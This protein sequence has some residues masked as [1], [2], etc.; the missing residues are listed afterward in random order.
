MSYELW[1][2]SKVNTIDLDI[3]MLEE[4]GNCKNNK[5]TKLVL[6]TYFNKPLPRLPE[7]IKQVDFGG[8][9]AQDISNIGDH[10]ETLKFNSNKFIHNIGTFSKKLKNLYIHADNIESNIDMKD[11]PNELG[12]LEII[13]TS[14]NNS[15]QIN[16]TKL[17]SLKIIS[18]TYNHEISCLPI[19]T[20]VLHIHS[21]KFNQPLDNLPHNLKRLYIHS[22]AFNQPLDNLPPALEELTLENM[23]SFNKILS[24]LPCGIKY[25]SLNFRP[26]NNEY[27]HD[28]TGLI[29]CKTL[30][31]AN[32][33]GNLN[34]LNN[35]IE[36]LNIWCT[37]NVIYEF[38]EY[39]KHWN[40]FP[41]NLKILNI[42]RE[43]V[44]LNAIHDMT[45]IIKANIPCSN[46]CINGILY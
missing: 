38:R 8:N 7:Y 24:N 3:N 4:L 29:N 34:V 41:S 40:K 25:F 17:A 13:C 15:I 26:F 43:L 39:L 6:D 28:I 46:I 37:P 14:F 10:I 1:F 45:D 16:N 36:E 35:S 5:I 32:Y 23:Y 30:K 33:W 12:T 27:T 44:H 19:T 9:Y 18:I 11:F 42:N 2:R 31:L 22:E 20:E 21:D